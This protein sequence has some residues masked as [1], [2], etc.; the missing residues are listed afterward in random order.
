MLQDINLQSQKDDKF[1]IKSK[2]STPEYIINFSKLN[3]EKN[4]E[5][6]QRNNR[7]PIG[8]HQCGYSSESTKARRKWCNIFQVLKVKNCQVQILY[9]AKSFIGND[10][11]IKTVSHEGKL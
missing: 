1:Q 4:L 7:L 10:G 8:K 9:P 6:S 3:T 5:S 11:R 2:K